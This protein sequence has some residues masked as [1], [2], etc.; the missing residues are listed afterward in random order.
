MHL[1]NADQAAGS[2]IERYGE[3][4]DVPPRVVLDPMSW[5]GHSSGSAPTRA[6]L[7]E[8]WL[9]MGAKP[10]RRALGRRDV[11]EWK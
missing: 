9:R 3:T 1:Y 5:Y 6:R 11:A 4:A 10:P 7:F 2:L 8:L